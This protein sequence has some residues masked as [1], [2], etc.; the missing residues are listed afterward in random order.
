MTYF[1]PVKL[2]K[3]LLL[4]F[5]LTFF[6]LTAFDKVVIWGHKLHSH[7]HSYIHNAFY[8]AFTHLGYP[9]YWLD[10]A[11]ELSDFDFRNTLFI[12]EGQ[13]DRQI[14]LRKDCSYMLHNCTDTK[15]RMLPKKNVISFQVYTDSIFSVPNLVKLDTCLYYDL[16]GRCL[17]MPW[18][19][20]LLP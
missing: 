3:S 19:T 9:T 1:Y 4:L 15:Y 7:T 14:P 13:V 2:M 5:I 12:T 6:Q 10:D 18:A 11:E 17:Y 8:I 20:D 16:A